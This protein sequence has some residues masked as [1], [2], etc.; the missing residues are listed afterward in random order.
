MITI[1]RG[2][3]IKKIPKESFIIYRK[4][5]WIEIKEAKKYDKT[6]TKKKTPKSSKS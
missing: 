4:T 6:N 1:Q 3:I 5:G 2:D